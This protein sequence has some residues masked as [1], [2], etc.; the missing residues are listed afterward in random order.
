M[1]NDKTITLSGGEN[2][3]NYQAQGDINVTGHSSEEVA[4]IISSAVEPLMRII[5]R[6]TGEAE[7]TAIKRRDDA[8]SKTINALV[9]D[10]N[11]VA[12]LQKF[13]EPAVQLVLQSVYKEYM[14]TDDPILG[15]GLIDLLMDRLRAEERTT[16]QCL[17]DEAIQIL[18]KLTNEQ[19]D[20]IALFVFDGLAHSPNNM[21]SFKL[22]YEKL[23]PLPKSLKAIKNIRIEIDY[24]K[25]LNLFTATPGMSY[26]KNIYDN[27][28]RNYKCLMTNGIDIQTFITKLNTIPNSHNYG[29]AYQIPGKDRFTIAALNDK[30]L[31]DIINRHK[32]HTYKSVLFEIFN[33]NLMNDEEIKAFFNTINPNWAAY[34]DVFG[35][36]KGIHELVPS[37]LAKFIGLKRL[38]NLLDE[39][40]S[41]D[42]LYQ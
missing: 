38:S 7:V 10:E 39:K 41:L 29:L 4:E 35:S 14:K 18:P 12:L 42:I 33:T 16:Q 37:L 17:I 32:L 15:D 3:S 5:E 6:L 28:R 25:Q 11:K 1:I 19:L 36:E 27:Y 23:S 21:D 22:F 8:Q 31:E 30:V 9:E 13:K 24:L 34:F 26:Q 2:S 40:I 20:F